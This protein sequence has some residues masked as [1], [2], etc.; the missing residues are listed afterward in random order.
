MN[1]LWREAVRDDVPAIVT[2]LADDV[3]GQG[4]ESD[5]VAP[6]YAAF[7]AMQT[8]GGN[9][10][11]VGE[12]GGLVVATYQLTM[13]SGLSL[14][15]SRRAQVESVRVAADQRGAGLGAALMQD[16]E[17]RA[18]AGG[19][20]LIQLTSNRARERAHGFYAGLG[21]VASHVGFKKSLRE[22]VENDL[23]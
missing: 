5:D 16:A 22:R 21:Y 10:L 11:I 9:Q 1:V 4:R 2:M 17:A 23:P 13:I 15:A 18:R 8:E 19:C 20:A 12:I 14:K 3:L 6:Y 7:E